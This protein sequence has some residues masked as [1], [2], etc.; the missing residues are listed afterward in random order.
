MN[1][2]NKTKSRL[3]EELH[4]ARKRIAA[5]E[6]FASQRLH[7]EEAQ[8]QAEE[9]LRDTEERFRLAFNTSPDSININRLDDG[10]YVDINEGFTAVTGFTREDVIGK[11]SVEINIWHDPD[12]RKKLVHALRS[13]GYYENL[14]AQ[15]RRKDGSIATTL[16]SA[17]II[18]LKGVPHVISI[19][20][21]ITERKK[22]EDKLRESE[23]R[24]REVQEMAHLGYW[25]WDVK[26]GAVE[27]SEE[28]YKTFRLDPQEFTPHIDS[29]QAL[30]PWPEDHE[31][32]K[33][34]IRRAMESHEKGDYEQRF[35]R[36]DKSIGYYYSTFQGHYDDRGNL[37]SIFGS[38]MDIT[39]RKQAEKLLRESEQRYRLITDNITDIIF[40][41]DIWGNYT[42]ISPSH[43]RV[44]ERGE[45]V[46]GRS[47]FEYVHP[48]DRPNVVA[49]FNEAVMNRS[50]ARA[51]F[52][53]LHPSRGYIWLEAE[54]TLID[55]QGTFTGVIVSRDI[56]ERKQAEEERIKLEERLQ[57]SYKME[58][59]GSLAGGIAH[60]FNNILASILGFAE[61]IKLKIKDRVTTEDASDEI[62]KA[63]VR[64][65]D[66]VKQILTFS[67][68]TGIKRE[69]LAVVPLIKET[70]KF[71]RASLPVTIEIRQDFPVSSSMVVANPTQ[72]HQVIMNLCSNAAYAMKEKGG[73]L[74]IRLAEKEL[75]DDAELDFKELKRGRYL[76][77]S[78]TD[79]GCGIPKEI[80][81][82]IFDPF[83]TTKERGEGTGMGLAV[84]HGIVNDIGGAITVY[85]EPGKGTSFNILL[86]LYE[87]QTTETRALNT[88]MK[89]GTGKIL[90]VDDEEGVIASGRGILEQLGY[91]ITSTTSP[92]MA[93][94][95]FMSNPH[96]F[97]LVLTD[98]TMPKMTGLELSE[99]LWKI[100]PGI[101]IVL[102]T[103]FSQGISPERI[104][105][106]GIREM[107]MKP[108]VAS[109]LSEAV[110]RALNPSADR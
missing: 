76:R 100:R 70:L 52:R 108:M 16:M 61:L 86:P 45:E 5:L 78:V 31:R 38:V 66:L 48:D 69:P 36:P 51:D 9:D 41:T 32:D 96:A 25:Y 8:R 27:W 33:E 79:T 71:L 75:D 12:N 63:G 77:L 59:I 43:Q 49:T 97:D 98:M 80:I 37:V 34:L 40:T 47:I 54:G 68:Q 13:K 102:C 93:L 15:F 82:R 106:V 55:M 26:T 20:R 60:D 22:V 91:T 73:I 39:E 94:E 83:F 50:I 95:L 57:Q 107:V 87:G 56:T 58:A 17:R 30:S 28:V 24:L 90:F 21:D 67:R 105:D 29:I 10:L 6:D 3:I 46:L 4:E 1:D 23:R 53:Y 62:L 101:P 42:F 84:V 74:D 2:N 72:I 44:L 11:T 64:A 88:P 81:N 99:Q 19:T 104:R 89:A 35:L 7:A 110:F 85:S 92:I 109:E 65:R 18:K 103:G 14:E